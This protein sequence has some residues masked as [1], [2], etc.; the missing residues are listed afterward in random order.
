[1]RDKY[2]DPDGWKQ[3]TLRYEL[4]IGRGLWLLCGTCQKSRY[5]DIAEWAQK[6]GVDLDTPLKDAR[7][8]DTVSALRHARRVSLRRAL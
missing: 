8:G 1:M 6:H 3:C 2:Y 4:E 5:F 7:A